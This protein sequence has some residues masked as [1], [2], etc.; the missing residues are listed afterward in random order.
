MPPTKNPAIEKWI[1]QFM[2][3]SV[4]RT[5]SLIMT[6]FGDAIFPH[7]GKVW[8]GSLIELLAPFGVS[9]RLVRTSVFR[10]AEEGWLDARREGRRSL[11]TLNASSLSR[12]EHAYQRVYAPQDRAWQGKW[13]LLFGLPEQITA[14]QRAK[15]RKE[16]LWEGFGMLGP[17]S[18]AHPDPNA[19]VI[20][21]ILDRTGVRDVIFVCTAS[22]SEALNGRP[23]SGLVQECWQLD[24]VA[25]DYRHYVEQFASLPQLRQMR[26]RLD[27]EQAFV[28]RT[29]AIHEF[30]RA[31]LNDP[32][33][34][35]EMLPAGWPGKTAYDL[36]HRIYR[37]T[38]VEAQAY[39][40]ASLRHED[41]SAPEAAPFFYQRF[42]GLD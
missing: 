39:V 24:A 29:L 8:L 35:L 30:R 37:T 23:L 40:L 21:E 31:Q 7:E 3:H 42:G 36:C 4:P 17:T 10:L 14:S 11:Y 6:L 20:N 34:P 1:E 26:A 15:L 22:Q 32:L 19:E 38:C 28:L 5:K 9:D 27:P 25:A 18:F 2:S 16:L 13:T 12:F 33:L 41:E